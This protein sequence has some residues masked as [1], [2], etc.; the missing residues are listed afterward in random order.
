MTLGSLVLGSALLLLAAGLLTACLRLRSA[1]DFL[2]GF[3]L[4][5]FTLVVVIELLLSPGHDL[6]QTWLLAVLAGVTVGTAALWIALGRPA[7][8]PFRPAL[9]AC[10]E[11]LRDPLV[12]ILS[13]A[14]LAAFG[15]V[16]A[17]IVGT[18]PNDYD[19]L[20]YH[21]A[22]AAFWKQQHA[23]AY[24]AGANDARLNGFPPNAEIAASFTMILGKTERFVGFV[25]LAA[26]LATMVADGRDRPAD[27]AD[28]APGA[29]R[30]AAVRD[31]AG[32]RPPVRDGAQRPRLR[33]L[34]GLLRVLPVHV[35][36]G[37]AGARGARAR[38]RARHE[39]HGAPRPAAAGGLR[40]LSPPG[41]PLAGARPRRRQRDRARGVLVPA[42]HRED[43]PHQRRDRGREERD[44]GRARQHALGR[45]HDRALHAAR[46][47][48]GRPVRRGRP[49]PVPLP[50]RGGADP[51]ARAARARAR[52]HRARR[53]GR[54][55]RRVAARLPLDRPRAAARLPEAVGALRPARSRL[56]RLRQAPDAGE[57]VPVLVR[58]AR[59]RARD[60]VL[61]ARLDRAA[62]R[63]AAARRLGAGPG[64]GDLARPA[65]DHD[66]LQPLG[67][68][69]CRLRG[70][71]RRCALGAGAADQASR[72]GGDRRSASSRSGWRSSTTTRS[73]R[74]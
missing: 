29:V 3:Y 30:G 19:V 26:L 36:A 31:A 13:V 8:P 25:Q 69:L 52:G 68:A 6:T 5:A 34:P 20:W 18:A 39:V 51:R 9:A 50:R 1:T 22:R 10:R 23:I 33:V 40:G 41:P 11:A 53:R 71:A 24:I 17:L 58:R 70:R 2:L 49:R 73:R 60:R 21:L 47:R 32:R 42:Q 45:R 48:R 59:A 14:V 37:D 16:A 74:G 12:A 4:V 54:G 15:Y 62:A 44:H 66:L 43:A 27:R 35:A 57:P 72:V 61:R 38:S 7:P 46:H 67:R 63:L 64:A 28:R 56:P 55:A 65:V